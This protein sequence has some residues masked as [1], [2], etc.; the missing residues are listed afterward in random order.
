MRLHNPANGHNLETLEFC[1]QFCTIF[2]FNI[3]ISTSFLRVHSCKCKHVIHQY[4]SHDYIYHTVFYFWKEFLT[5][6]T[7]STLNLSDLTSKIHVVTTLATL[8][9]RTI[10]YTYC[11]HMP[12]M[13]C[14]MPSSSSTLVTHE[15]RI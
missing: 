1:L 4:T 12:G 2:F 8:K 14:H 3:H 9:L 11:V 7:L 10:F 13:M 5:Y 6:T 15:L